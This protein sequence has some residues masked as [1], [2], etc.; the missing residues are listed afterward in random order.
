VTDGSRATLKHEQSDKET[1]DLRAPGGQLTLDSALRLARPRTNS[2]DH[3]RRLAHDRCHCWRPFVSDGNRKVPA[4]P[5][6]LEPPDLIDRLHRRLFT[7]AGRSM[8]KVIRCTASPSL[9][10]APAAER[11][12]LLG[13]QTYRTVVPTVRLV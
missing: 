8:S 5:V 11:A 12:V 6:C 9:A 1:V 10:A 4:D 7:V 2:A 3:E 13:P